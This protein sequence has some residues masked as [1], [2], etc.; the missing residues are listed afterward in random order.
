MVSTSNQTPSVVLHTDAAK[1]YKLK[2]S[3]VLH[4]HVGH[5]KKRMKVKGKWIWKLPSFVRVTT[6]KDTHTHKPFVVN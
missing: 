4:D 5:C 3:G 6:H 1:S 2:M